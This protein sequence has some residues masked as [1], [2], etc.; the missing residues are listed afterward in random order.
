VKLLKLID[1]DVLDPDT[2]K[3][4]FTKMKE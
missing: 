4:M 3:L 2:A 1:M